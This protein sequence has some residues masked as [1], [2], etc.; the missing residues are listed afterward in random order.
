MPRVMGA[1]Q[2]VVRRSFHPATGGS[3]RQK[4]AGAF[5]GP[6]V[7]VTAG[8]RDAGMTEG[9]LKRV[10][11]GPAV[12][13]VGGV[14]RGEPVRTEGHVDAGPFGRVFYD[15]KNRHTLESPTLL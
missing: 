12:G 10:E 7:Q 8:R 4:T 15:S 14:G 9:S 6:G 13:G 5:F 2:C 1:M 11:G 3:Q